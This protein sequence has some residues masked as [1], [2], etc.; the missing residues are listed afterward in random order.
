M[1]RSAGPEAG[2][3][4][5]HSSE[6]AAAAAA[7]R[8]PE[9]ASSM[10][11][12]S[13]RLR[14]SMKIASSQVRTVEI[15]PRPAPRNQPAMSCASSGF[16]LTTMIG[17]AFRS[18]M[19]SLLS[20]AVAF[21]RDRSP[22]APGQDVDPSHHPRQPQASPG[23]GRSCLWRRH[24]VSLTFV[25]YRDDHLAGS[26]VGGDSDHTC[27]CA[28]DPRAPRRVSP[29]ALQGPPNHRNGQLPP[30]GCRE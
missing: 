28:M 20:K 6:Y 8:R 23:A 5:R 19:Q 10:I 26:P 12:R 24:I 18:I 7:R 27:G 15:S 11:S 17:A 1:P 30:A 21:H 16:G 13:G 22:A 14:P 9:M 25:G 3:P 2:L 4:R 29:G